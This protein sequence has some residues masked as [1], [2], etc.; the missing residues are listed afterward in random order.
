M[1]SPTAK[2]LRSFLEKHGFP[3]AVSAV[4]QADVHLDEQVKHSCSVWERDGGH[5][6]KV[7]EARPAPRFSATPLGIPRGAPLLGEHTIELLTGD[8][9]Y[10]RERVAQLQDGGALGPVATLDSRTGLTSRSRHAVR[11]GSSC[12]R[13]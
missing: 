13:A 8:L 4:S 6:G 3:A 9:G 7:R 5:V 10:S 2:E 11:L 1:G 12:T